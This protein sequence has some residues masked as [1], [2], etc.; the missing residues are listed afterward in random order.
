VVQLHHFVR[1]L[2]EFTEYQAALQHL[3]ANSGY[4]YY[5]TGNAQ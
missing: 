5:Y 3:G 2:A 4:R 1:A